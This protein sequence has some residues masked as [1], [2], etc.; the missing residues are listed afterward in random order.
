[1]SQ[2]VH[3]TSCPVCG[4]TGIAPLLT[5]KD[6]SVSGEDYVVWQCADCTLRFTQDAP[7]AES[8]G[9]YYKSSEYI[10]HTDSRKG[11]INRVYQRVRRITMA[12]KAGLIERH[13]A[14]KKGRL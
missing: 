3:Y 11:M 6:H 9:T 5:V 13:T 12:G 14:L 2:T 7:G 8:I 10:S 4:G 1:M